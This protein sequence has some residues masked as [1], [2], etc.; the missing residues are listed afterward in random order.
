MGL[1]MPL[2]GIEDALRELQNARRSQ[3]ALPTT[4]GGGDFRPLIGETPPAFFSTPIDY[5]HNII[6]KLL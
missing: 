5:Y 3:V 6:I 4:A 2:D 1:G